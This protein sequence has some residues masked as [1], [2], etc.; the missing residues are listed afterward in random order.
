MIEHVGLTDAITMLREL[1]RVMRPGV[2][3]IATPE[4]DKIVTLKNDQ[5]DAEQKNYVQY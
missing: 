5:L 1:H 3:H 2:L 4:I